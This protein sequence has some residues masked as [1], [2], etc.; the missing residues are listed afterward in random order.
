MSNVESWISTSTGE[1]PMT[2][3]DVV[4]ERLRGTSRQLTVVEAVKRANEAIDTRWKSVPSE[5]ER[6]T[7]SGLS[8][9]DALKKA[10]DEA[11]AFETAARARLPKSKDT[12]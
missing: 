12:A 8:H 10:R 7:A 2:A 1:E 6:L 9:E 11:Q 5:V 4:L 3:R